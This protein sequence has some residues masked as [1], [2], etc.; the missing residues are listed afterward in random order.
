MLAYLEVF[1][2]KCRGEDINIEVWD[3]FV[4]LALHI[5]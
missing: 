5:A 4:W 1:K 3:R 2:K